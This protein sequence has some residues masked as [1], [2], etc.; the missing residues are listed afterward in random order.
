MFDKFGRGV[1]TW[2]ELSSLLKALGIPDIPIGLLNRMA[3]EHTPENSVGLDYKAFL[4][5][6]QSEPFSDSLDYTFNR[7]NSTYNVRVIKRAIVLLAEGF[8]TIEDLRASRM[9]FT[10]YEGEMC[11]GLQL[12]VQ[13]V[14]AVMRVSGKAIAPRKLQT[15]LDSVEED[16]P[17][18]LQ[19]YEFLDLVKVCNDRG[20]Q[21]KAIPGVSTSIE[22]SKIGLF[23][24]TDP[25]FLLTPGQKLSKQ[26]DTDYEDMMNLMNTQQILPRDMSMSSKNSNS[27]D[28]HNRTQMGRRSKR[29]DDGLDL[30][31]QIRDSIKSS[32][33]QVSTARATH[34]PG[35]SRPRTAY[36]LDKNPSLPRLATTQRIFKERRSTSAPTMRNSEGQR[37]SRISDAETVNFDPTQK[38]REMVPRHLT[39]SAPLLRGHYAGKEKVEG[40]DA[41]EF[42]IPERRVDNY[43]TLRDYITTNGETSLSRVI[44]SSIGASYKRPTSPPLSPHTRPEERKKKV[45]NK[46]GF[47]ETRKNTKSLQ[48]IYKDRLRGSPITNIEELGSKPSTAEVPTRVSS[49]KKADDSEVDRATSPIP[50]IGSSE[51]VSRSKSKHE[52]PPRISFQLRSSR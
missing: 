6:L 36:T 37:T 23:E 34:S 35:S 3:A 48:T 9:G 32:G 24:L 1:I 38:E 49:M 21:S 16:V 10:L 27:L 40:I 5:L 43:E 13:C 51:E 2:R 12:D 14:S 20:E 17:G 4:R 25:N 41:N 8:L 18:R 22:R 44:T 31:G 29:T 19:L 26:M 52:S 11:N 47:E 30:Y 42:A 33:V 46:R 7:H 45:K 50:T 15:W 28:F 39:A